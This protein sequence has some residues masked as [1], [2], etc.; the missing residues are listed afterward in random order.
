MGTCINYKLIIYSQ[1]PHKVVW[2][3]LESASTGWRKACTKEGENPRTAVSSL[4]KVHPG[5]SLV[6]LFY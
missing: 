5:K 6:K 4:G 1:R 3:I 2:D